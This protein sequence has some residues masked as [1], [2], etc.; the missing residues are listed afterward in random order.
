MELGVWV[1]VSEDVDTPERLVVGVPLMDALLVT[2]PD[3]LTEDED[4]DVARAVPEDERECVGVP[5][6]L[7]LSEMLLDLVS[8]PLNEDADVALAADVPETL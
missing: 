2:K 4:D 1:I 6:L 3:L 5:V 8:D 7:V